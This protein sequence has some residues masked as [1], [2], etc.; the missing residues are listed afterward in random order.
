MFGRHR[1]REV[2]MVPRPGKPQQGQGGNNSRMSGGSI[3][4][5]GTIL[6]H[7]ISE[8]HSAAALSFVI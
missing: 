6:F 8:V 1:R 5:R 3:P 4:P 2:P 7:R